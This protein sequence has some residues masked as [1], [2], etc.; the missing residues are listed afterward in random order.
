MTQSIGFIY[1]L[2][3][4]LRVASAYREA[5]RVM[6]AI[7]TGAEIERA[8]VGSATVQFSAAQQSGHEIRSGG[9]PE[10]DLAMEVAAHH[11]DCTILHMREE[12]WVKDLE[13]DDGLA[14]MMAVTG[15]VKETLDGAGMIVEAIAAALLERGEILGDGALAQIIES[16][17]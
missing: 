17:A 2:G 7:T 9:G 13:G 16:A 4:R 10:M 1:D 15:W 5:A 8:W 6:V 14:A 11:A 3:R 12:E